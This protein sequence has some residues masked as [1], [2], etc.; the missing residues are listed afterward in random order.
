M[1][2]DNTPFNICVEGYPENIFFDR[3]DPPF[4]KDLSINVL[5]PTYL[6]YLDDFKKLD[7]VKQGILNEATISTNSP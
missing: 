5:L 4:P 6:I 1:L 3:Y 7:K 2:V